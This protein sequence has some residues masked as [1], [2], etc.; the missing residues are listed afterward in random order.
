MLIS[1]RG[2]EMW[3]RACVTRS[4]GIAVL[5]ALLVPLVVASSADAQPFAYVL[6]QRSPSNTPAVVSVIDTSSNT[7]TA[8][9]TVGPDCECVNSNGIAIVP[10]AGRVYVSH[11]LY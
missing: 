7:I 3:V 10:D 11:Q 4:A 5:M 6:G 8:S 2:A 9:I 1:K